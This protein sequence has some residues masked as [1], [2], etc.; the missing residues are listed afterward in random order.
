M[1]L[2]VG[3]RPGT[4]EVGVDLRVVLDAPHGGRE[5]RRL[6]LDTFGPG[7]HDSAVGHVGDD[8]VVPVH[9]AARGGDR[10][11]QRVEVGVR[12]PPHGAQAEGLATRVRLDHSAEGHGGELVSEADAQHG[13]AVG[14]VLADP[15]PGRRQPRAVGVVVGSHR[16]AQHDQ[17]VVRRGVG[18]R[19]SGVGVADGQGGPGVGEPGADQVGRAVR[20]VLDHGYAD[21]AHRSVVPLEQERG[22]QGEE[23][24][25]DA[26][27]PEDGGQQR[28][29]GQQREDT[30][31]DAEQ[32]GHSR[33][34][35]QAVGVPSAR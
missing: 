22:R 8:V 23:A 9:A 35:R 20:L 3:H 30:G 4:D 15:L 34:G 7:Q 16:T 18:Q 2:A 13:Y 25:H 5:P 27:Q 31:E 17:A 11:H 12:G 28:E 14:G 21:P 26:D 6:H 24:G 10:G 29:A 1:E 32:A 19:L 33:P